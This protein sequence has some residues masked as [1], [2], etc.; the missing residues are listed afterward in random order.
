MVKL[1]K[2][3]DLR[4]HQGYYYLQSRY[5]DPETQRFLNADSQL[6]QGVLGY[7]LFAYCENDPINKIDFNGNKSK[8]GKWLKGAGIALVGVIA[9]TTTVVTA[10]AAAPAWVAFASCVA[11]AAGTACVA[12]GVSE[13]VEAHTGYN[14]I[15]DGL[16]KGDQKTYD[17]SRKTVETVASVGSVVTGIGSAIPNLPS[18]PPTNVG[19]PFKT[20]GKI[21]SIQIGVNPNTLIPTKDLNTLN[22]LR[23]ADAVK[24]AG[25]QALEVTSGGTILQ[26][27][28]R[29]ADAIAKGRPV[30]VIITIFGD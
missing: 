1:S 22:P 15:R 16:M 20:G 11:G 4:Q 9:I 10:G 5:Y 25:N 23:I 12:Y 19:V 2:T 13:M 28:H 26:G 14:V 30:D 27:H 3:G 6:N 21:G 24:Y 7:N 17:T 18:S 8:F 29:V